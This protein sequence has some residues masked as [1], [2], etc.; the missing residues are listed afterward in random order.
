MHDVDT[1]VTAGAS[2]AADHAALLEAVAARGDRDAFRA[3]Y[4]HWEPRIRAYLRRSGAADADAEELAQDVLAAMW[5]NAHSYRASKASAAT[6]IFTIARNRRIDHFRR[7]ARFAPDPT[8]PAFVPDDRDGPEATSAQAGD[9]RDLAA[10]IAALPPE[11]RAV[12]EAFYFADKPAHS[13][14]VETSLPLGTVK[15]RLRLALARLRES[16]PKAVA[17]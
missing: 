15:S 14:A 4:E 12:L 2:P 6:W 9:R 3:L 5:N 11:Q 8:D 1:D 10:A 17:L 16:M 7:G 13:I